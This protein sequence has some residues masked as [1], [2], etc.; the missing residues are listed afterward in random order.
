MRHLA[1]PDNSQIL[2][3]WCWQ[4]DLFSEV[5]GTSHLSFAETFTSAGTAFRPSSPATFWLR[6]QQK[7]LMSGPPRPWEMDLHAHPG[8]PLGTKHERKGRDVR[9]NARTARWRRSN[10]SPLAGV[11]CRQKQRGLPVCTDAA[12]RTALEGSADCPSG[13]ATT[14]IEQ[15]SG[16]RVSRNNQPF[17]AFHLA[18][19]PLVHPATGHIL[20]TCPALSL[21]TLC[22]DPYAQH[23]G[24]QRQSNRSFR[25]RSPACGQSYQDRSRKEKPKRQPRRKWCR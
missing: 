16:V 23:G 13:V 11:G 17:P 3:A 25:K 8:R 12:S 22:P 4:T 20:M 10:A 18:V 19:I 15:C 6:N 7:H 14:R 21:K 2:I 5:E 24:G 9:G 1:D